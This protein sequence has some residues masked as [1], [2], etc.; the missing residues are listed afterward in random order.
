M[1]QDSD[2]NVNDTL[3]FAAILRDNAGLARMVAH[4]VKTQLDLNWATKDDV[5]DDV[6]QEILADMDEG[7]I[8]DRLREQI[9]DAYSEYGHEDCVSEQTCEERERDARNEGYE[10]GQHAADCDKE[11]VEDM[12]R[13]LR[14]SLDG[15]MIEVVGSDQIAPARQVHAMYT[16]WKNGTLS[17][18]EKQIGLGERTNPVDRI[19]SYP[20]YRADDETISVGCMKF[21]V[22]EIEYLAKAMGWYET[23]LA[24]DI[25]KNGTLTVS[26]VRDGKTLHNYNLD[27]PE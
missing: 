4:Y 25:H 3:D 18:E 1:R 27:T 12:P 2:D 7:D 16:K 13:C 5:P 6:R 24:V 22:A 26:V 15:L 9:Y 8:P 11:H 19:A 10:D 23:K 20:I 21:N 14:P 17:T